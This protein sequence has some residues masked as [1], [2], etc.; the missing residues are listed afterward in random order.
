[1]DQE[2]GVKTTNGSGKFV[3]GQITYDDKRIKPGIERLCYDEALE[4]Y[5][6]GR[7]QVFIFGKFRGIFIYFQMTSLHLRES[8][9]VQNSYLFCQIIL[10]R[11]QICL[12]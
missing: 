7:Y 11:G 6:S 2:L 3:N 10:N 8:L 5:G 4:K 12:G 1:M 9:S